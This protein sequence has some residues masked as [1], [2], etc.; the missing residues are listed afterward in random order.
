VD[1]KEQLLVFLFPFCEMKN[2]RAWSTTLMLH[3]L[4]EKRKDSLLNTERRNLYKLVIMSIP[5]PFASVS[6]TDHLDIHGTAALYRQ[7]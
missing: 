4:M 2:I 1:R 6:D 7:D 3:L 5:V